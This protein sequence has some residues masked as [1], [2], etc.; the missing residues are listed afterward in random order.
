MGCGG[1]NTHHNYY[2]R[3]IV[4]QEITVETEV[5][6]ERQIILDGHTFTL[7]DT[8]LYEADEPYIIDD[9]WGDQEEHFNKIMIFKIVNGVKYAWLLSDD[10]KN[11][12]SAYR[13]FMRLNHGNKWIGVDIAYDMADMNLGGICL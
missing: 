6:M 4:T 2:L 5:I 9:D 11:H 1:F 3:V 10:K 13:N 8:G 12:H 7:R